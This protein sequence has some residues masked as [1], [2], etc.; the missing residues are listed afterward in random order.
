M[1]L[2]RPKHIVLVRLQYPVGKSAKG[3]NPKVTVEY[4]IKLWLEFSKTKGGKKV[5][6]YVN[7]PWS[8][9]T[10]S[11]TIWSLA[12][13]SFR[14]IFVRFVSW[15]SKSK[16]CKYH[17]KTSRNLPKE[18]MNY[19]MSNCK[20][21]HLMFNEIAITMNSTIQNWASSNWEKLAKRS[22]CNLYAIWWIRH[23]DWY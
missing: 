9:L 22:I 21:Y 19:H 14:R 11:T 23:A 16:I 3:S 5:G 15:D 20:T 2:H 13:R 12:H 17:S 10:P 8:P 7:V 6:G 18:R 4:S 1:S